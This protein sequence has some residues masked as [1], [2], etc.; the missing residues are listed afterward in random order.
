MTTGERVS[1]EDRRQLLDDTV[2]KW[3]ANGWRVEQRDGYQA[4][5][6]KGKRVN[7]I[8]HLL[9]TIITAGVWAIVWI[10]LAIAGGQRH[11]VVSIDPSGK[12][13]ATKV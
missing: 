8:L 9:L 2:Q 3:A 6:V 12:L 5:L 1:D 13:V 7:H 10:A 11:Q 4:T